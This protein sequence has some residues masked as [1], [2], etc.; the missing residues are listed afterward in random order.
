MN[1][2]KKQQ[3]QWIDHI[4][5]LPTDSICLKEQ[6]YSDTVDTKQKTIHAKDGPQR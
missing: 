5:R 6:C 4:R 2:I 1:F 3:N